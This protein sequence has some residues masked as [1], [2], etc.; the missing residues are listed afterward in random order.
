MFEFG[1]GTTDTV[2]LTITW[3]EV[4]S[5]LFFFGIH[6]GQYPRIFATIARRSG[7][8]LDSVVSSRWT[9]RG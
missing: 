5:A 3:R 6:D 9:T 2:P 1:R 8:D 7:N 4:R